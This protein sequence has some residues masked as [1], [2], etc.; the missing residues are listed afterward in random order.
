V[1]ELGGGEI[2]GYNFDSF[3]WGDVLHI[4]AT[5]K[6]VCGIRDISAQEARREAIAH[7]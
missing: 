6:D 2:E 5:E 7:G 1:V 4:H 3:L